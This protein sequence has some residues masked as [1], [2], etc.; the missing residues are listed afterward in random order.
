MLLNGGRRVEITIES[1]SEF[2]ADSDL[3]R[4]LKS[5]GLVL[6]LEGRTQAKT[7]LRIKAEFP[8]V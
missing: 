6:G 8:A 5:A 2:A 4:R 1:E 3:A 7:L